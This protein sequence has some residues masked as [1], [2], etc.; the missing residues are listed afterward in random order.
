MWPLKLPAILVQQH[1]Q[2]SSDRLQITEEVPKTNPSFTKIGISHFVHSC[3]D[4]S[5]QLV[6][7]LLTFP[8]GSLAVA[9]S[10]LCQFFF[11]LHLSLLSCIWTSFSMDF[12]LLAFGL[13]PIALLMNDALPSCPTAVG[14]YIACSQHFLSSSSNLSS[15]LQFLSLGCQGC[16]RWALGPSAAR[17]SSDT[18]R[19][20]PTHR[21]DTEDQRSERLRVTRRKIV[22]RFCQTP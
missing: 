15:N 7:P 19:C 22:R 4:R 17:I 2:W 3:P 16:C 8:G 11:F 13:G 10:F 1:H 5:S 6:S 18:K 21:T 12:F 9:H 20:D 14:S